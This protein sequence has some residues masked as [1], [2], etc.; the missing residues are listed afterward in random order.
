MGLIKMASKSEI[1]RLRKPT[2]PS[3]SPAY[4]VSYLVSSSL[5]A[6][7]SLSQAA[8]TDAPLM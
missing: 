3:P 7:L 5:L 1:Q 2:S 6:S 4:F 8:G